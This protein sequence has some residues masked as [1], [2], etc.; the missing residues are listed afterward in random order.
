MR[1]GR[2]GAVLGSIER[3]FRSGTAAGLSDRQLLERFAARHDEAAE[4]A[5]AALVER[6]GPM[7]LTVCRRVLGDP[8][9]AHDAFQATFLVLVRRA[10]SVRNRDSLASWLY[11]VALRVSA[12]ARADR[13]RRRRAEHDAG[14]KRPLVYEPDRQGT[15]TWE[16]VGRLPDPLRAAVVLCYLEGLTHEQAAA[17]LGW[18]V[19]TVRSRLAR[20]RDKL[21]KRLARHG[22][23]A[24]LLPQLAHRPDWLPQSLVEP[25]IRAAML[26]AARDAAEA[27]V[28]SLA[29]A[30]LTE[31]VLRTMLVTKIKTTALALAAAGSLATGAVV[32][33]N[34]EEKPTAAAAAPGPKSPD[35]DT[36]AKSSTVKAETPALPAVSS[37]LQEALQSW[38]QKAAKLKAEGKYAEAAEAASRIQAIAAKWSKLLWQQAMQSDGSGAVAYDP[39][40]PVTGGSPHE[41]KG[42]RVW[43]TWSH[44]GPANPGASSQADRS[45]EKGSS[46]A[47]KDQSTQPPPTSIPF[48]LGSFGDPFSLG[49]FGESFMITPLPKGVELNRRETYPEGSMPFFNG[50]D[51]VLLRSL[52][53]KAPLIVPTPKPPASDSERLGQLEKKVERVLRLLEGGAEKTAEPAGGLGTE[54]ERLRDRVKWCGERFKKGYLSA[55]QFLQEKRAAAQV[56]LKAARALAARGDDAGA[57]ALVDE[58]DGLDLKFSLFDDSPDKVRALIKAANTRTIDPPK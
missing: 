12:H 16:E 46:R 1:S 54:V 40:W 53:R 3:L 15:E 18:P 25:T 43:D 48:S 10:G 32:L 41:A 47:A 56:F 26:A 50:K 22:H 33:A 21:R 57:S 28:V 23:T 8:H 35:T 27:G 34:H 20:A 14:A 52:P 30:T 11:G 49:S 45:K 2:R 29:A 6:H 4:A 55:S 17:R 24:G 42:G 5:F 51:W 9:D 38:V 37:S 39:L 36:P 19:G 7:V 31:G 44:P 58:V 13:Q